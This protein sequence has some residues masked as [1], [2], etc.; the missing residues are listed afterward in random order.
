MRMLGLRWLTRAGIGFGLIAALAVGVQSGNSPAEAMTSQTVPGTWVSAIT[1]L[2]PAGSP[3]T[4]TV[5]LDFYDSAGKHVCNTEQTGVVAGA[6]KLWYVPSVLCNPAPPDHLTSFTLPAGAVYSAVVSADQKVYAVVNVSSS[7]PAAAEQYNG[8][9]RDGS[10]MG[11]ASVEYIPSVNREYYGASS[12]IVTQNAGGAPTPI[13]IHLVGTSS[14]GNINTCVISPSVPASSGYTLDLESANGTNGLPDLGTNFNGAATVFGGT[15]SPCG[16]TPTSSQQVAAVVTQ[17]RPD[18]TPPQ[19]GAT[20]AFAGGGPTAFIPGLYNNYYAVNSALI[21]QNADTTP[22]NITVSYV[23]A[24]GTAIDV[25][26]GLAPGASHLFYT[27][28]AGKSGGSGSLPSG[29]IGSATV[30]TSG[31]GGQKI[32]AQVNEAAS[33]GLASYPGSP[34]GTTHVFAPSLLKNYYGANGSFTIQNVDSTTATVQVTWGVTNST[35]SKCP[36]GTETFTLASAQS[37]A[38]YVPNDPCLN[39]TS[40]YSGGATITSTGGQKI[41]ALIGTAGSGTGAYDGLYATNAP[42]SN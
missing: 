1:V 2:N 25:V 39:V 31:S 32:L 16:T 38:V 40:T 20:N 28:N 9:P 12:T 5:D 42:G 19:F 14:K 18:A 4:A 11:V 26:N 24:K 17:Y 30:T 3:G 7:S 41:V 37:Q 33:N 15:S 23:G 35:S 34:S 6:S 13:T 36:G 29:W 8:V 21:V 10:T 27:P 22:A